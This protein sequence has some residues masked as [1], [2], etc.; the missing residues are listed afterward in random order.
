[1]EWVERLNAAVDELEAQ[2]DGKVDVERAARIAACSV[3]HFQRMFP[4]MTGVTLSEYI[5]R[6]RMTRAAFE[7][8]DGARIIDVAAR[9]GYESPTAFNRAFRSVHGV[10][11]TA[12]KK[13]GIDLAAYP[14]LA[15]TIS[16]KG[17]EAMNYRIEKKERIRVV[18]V[19]CKEPMT[20]EDS[21]EKVPKFWQKIAQEN[22]IPRLC[23]LMDGSEPAGVLGVSACDAD[24]FSGYYV[25][26][27]TRRPC[28]AEMNELEIPAR[29]HAVFECVGP[30][31]DAI[32]N[33]Q[34]RI[35][36]EWLPTSGY[37]YAAAPDIEVYFDGDQSAADYRSQVWLPIVKKEADTGFCKN[38][39]G[40]LKSAAVLRT[41]SYGPA[42]ALRQRHARRLFD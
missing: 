28:P 6:R 18:G 27:A 13:Q 11:P 20:M 39:W 33:L 22:W 26:A 38:I 31:P 35:L 23:A 16:I 29:T 17:E 24:G 36:T 34:K 3:F 21:F 10:A 30:M 5:R 37:E 8:M 40:R 7:L 32:Q 25:A 9:Y 12:A 15:F 19:G 41:S 42:P 1:M 2:L 4:Y 14:R